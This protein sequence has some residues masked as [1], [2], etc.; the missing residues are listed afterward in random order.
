[1]K[2]F[3]FRHYWDDKTWASKVEPAWLTKS[4]EGLSPELKKIKQIAD[5]LLDPGK[6]AQISRQNTDGSEILDGY[7]VYYRLVKKPDP[8][9]TNNR[10]AT[11]ITFCISRK[12]LN[13]E[14]CNWEVSNSLPFV[15]QK[16][17]I[18]IIGWITL[19]LAILL[20]MF[21]FLK[22]TQK[23]DDV[24]KETQK[25]NEE[26]ISPSIV[27]DTLASKPNNNRQIVH[28]KTELYRD[29]VCETEFENLT[30]N[31]TDYCFL[32]YAY[33]R[34]T[35]KSRISYD[36]W[37]KDPSRKKDVQ[38]MRYAKCNFIENTESDRDL[39]NFLRKKKSRKVRRSIE[40]FMLG[41]ESE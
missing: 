21:F 32:I 9:P 1:M 11:D 34:C 16:R 13:Q 27:V 19:S 33:Q 3:T 8:D 4:A 30:I 18:N 17:K 39:I 29:K 6:Y 36:R 38:N 37:L 5:K 10:I 7:Y 24:P 26:T 20:L 2:A 35:K 31:S 12:K 41:G 23:E 15:R 25:K 22:N 14:Q 28:E 40:K